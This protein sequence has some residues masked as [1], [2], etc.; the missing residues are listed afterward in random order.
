MS[1]GCKDI[2]IRKS[3]FVAKT[4]FLCE[5]F[6]Q[7]SHNTLFST[8]Q[9]RISH[10]SLIRHKFTRVKSLIGQMD[11]RLKLRLQSLSRDKGRNDEF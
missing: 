4:Q 2:G 7:R 6:E 5:S 8:R 3:K 11:G 9:I 1:L 10:T